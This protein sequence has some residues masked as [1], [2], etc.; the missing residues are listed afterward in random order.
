MYRL[1]RSSPLIPSALRRGVS[2]LELMV[3]MGL[4]SLIFTVL[5]AL[6]GQS[7]SL[8]SHGAR[9]LSLNQ[10]A[11]FA[12]DKMGPYLITATADGANSP[13]IRSPLPKQDAPSAGELQSYTNIQFSTTEDFLDATY[14]VRAPWDPD[15]A[16]RFYYEI[17]FDNVTNPI[18]YT[19]EDGT[20][21]NLGRILLRRYNDPG[22]ATPSD[23]S[24]YP[25]TPIA[26]NVQYFYCHRVASDAIEVLVHTVGKR[27]GPAGN[28]VDV[29]EEAQAILNVP[30]PR[31]Y[32]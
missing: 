20:N 23:T 32:Y 17:Y 30:T 5:I 24:V 31:Y 6:V 10:K 1:L 25:E 9:V 26:Y 8:V 19:L 7:S 14:D 2:L 4:I 29:F 3:V 13:A 22:F 11:R 16:A 15:S 21:I 12:L 18:P 28:Q 27:K